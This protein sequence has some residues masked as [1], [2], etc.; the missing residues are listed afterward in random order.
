MRARGGEEEEG[1]FNIPLHLPQYHP[2]MKI[3]PKPIVSINIEARINYNGDSYMSGGGS[4]GHVEGE[5]HLASLESR[6]RGVHRR[7]G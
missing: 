1:H 3:S 5:I 6:R 4:C 7:G 2:T